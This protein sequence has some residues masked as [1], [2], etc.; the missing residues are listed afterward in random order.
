MDGGVAVAVGAPTMSVP[1]LVAP[2]RGLT[3]KE[4]MASAGRRLVDF[5]PPGYSGGSSRPVKLD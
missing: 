4:P 2:V 1:D 3:V 5:H